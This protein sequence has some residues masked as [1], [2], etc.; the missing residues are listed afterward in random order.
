VIVLL[1]LLILAAILFPGG[2]R[3]LLGLLLAL[4]CFAIA[5]GIEPDAASKDN[6][7]TEQ[8]R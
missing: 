7:Q 2:V 4:L 3:A 5:A 1:L 8:V 6:E